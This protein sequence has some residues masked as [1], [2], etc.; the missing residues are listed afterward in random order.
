MIIIA[1]TDINSHLIGLDRATPS[2]VP[3]RD[4]NTHSVT[5]F[6]GLS[7]PRQDAFVFI[8]DVAIAIVN[9]C[10]MKRSFV[11]ETVS[12]DQ[13]YDEDRGLT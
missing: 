11:V 6:L 8:F 10:P 2:C 7:L 13:K 5:P 9:Y 4:R 12:S 3:T 1:N